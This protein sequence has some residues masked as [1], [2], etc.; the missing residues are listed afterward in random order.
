MKNKLK[1][2]EILN[3]IE[4]LIAERDILEESLEEN[5]AYQDILN[6]NYRLRELNRE[7]DKPS[8]FV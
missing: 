2:L 8:I 5:E 6:I 7:L 3:K 1:V 4:D